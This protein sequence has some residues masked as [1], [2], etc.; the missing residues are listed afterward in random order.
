M[1]A[2][3]KIRFFFEANL[4]KIVTTHEIAEVAGI[5]DYPRRIREL[6]DLEGLQIKSHNDRPD[7][8]PGQYILE[9]LER[10]P[11]FEHGISARTRAEVLARN[12][13][14]C[15]WCGRGPGDADPINP[16]RKIR[17]HIDH[18][19]PDGGNDKSNLRALCSACNQGK[20]NIQ[21]A[22]EKARDIIARI[23]KVSRNEKQEIYER[24]KEMLGE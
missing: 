21:P 9:T 6:R 14:T 1:S 12:G 19:D 2:R 22:S 4:S 11:A 17:L 13:F 5:R 18:I 23:R 7:L 24:L 10:L 16:N 3:D 15:Q 8:K 20:S